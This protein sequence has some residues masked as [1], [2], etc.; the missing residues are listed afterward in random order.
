[1][2]IMKEFL[3]SHVG[4]ECFGNFLC[5]KYSD[6]LVNK[7]L[8]RQYARIDYSSDELPVYS[9]KEGKCYVYN[10]QEEISIYNNEKITIPLHEISITIKF[11]FDGENI[12]S[13]TNDIALYT[14]ELKINEAFILKGIELNEMKKV[15]IIQKNLDYI[16]YK[17]KDEIVYTFSEILG[18]VYGKIEK[19]ELCGVA[20]R[21][22]SVGLNES[23]GIDGLF[24]GIEKQKV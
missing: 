9:I 13:Y 8:L 18:C 2:K 21:E 17:E 1:M 3:E 20:K 6:Q 15:I 12:Q 22:S 19:F 24:E 16:C 14:Q 11:K 23:E 10:K 5:K 7:S 4:R